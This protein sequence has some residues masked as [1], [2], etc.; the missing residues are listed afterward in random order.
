MQRTQMTGEGSAR[1][2]VQGGIK[3][4]KKKAK[5]KAPGAG[6]APGKRIAH[7]QTPAWD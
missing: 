1:F 3:T 7:H 2:T 5:S 6:P 4:R